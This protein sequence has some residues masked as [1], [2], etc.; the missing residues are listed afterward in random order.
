MF[1]ELIGS[2]DENR[3][4]LLDGNDEI[5]EIEKIDDNIITVDGS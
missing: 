3:D 4:R 5:V 1:K 2:D